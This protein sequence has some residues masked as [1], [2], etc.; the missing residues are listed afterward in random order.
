QL[1][2]PEPERG[3][4]GAAQSSIT[5]SRSPRRAARAIP[6][7]V[8]GRGAG[9]TGR[10]GPR[11]G[12]IRCWRCVG[13]G[14]GGLGRRRRRGRRVR[15]GGGASLRRDAT[16]VGGLRRRGTEERFPTLPAGYTTPDSSPVH[17]RG[18]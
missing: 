14:T 18:A 5:S 9:A 10:T 11:A 17:E 15:G 1:T 12:D 6:T 16:G 8:R 7:A 3:V 4:A 2:V 13:P